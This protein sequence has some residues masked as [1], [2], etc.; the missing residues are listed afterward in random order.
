MSYS[1]EYREQILKSVNKASFLLSELHRSGPSFGDTIQSIISASRLEDH[2]EVSR[3]AELVYSIVEALDSGGLD[4]NNEDVKS[5][6]GSGLGEIIEIIKNNR[7]AADPKIE[8]RMKL[9]LRSAK[10]DERDYVFSKMLKVLYVDEDKF[11]QSNIQKNMDKSIQ[12]ESCFSGE[13]ALQRLKIDKFDAILCD[14]KLTN[15]EILKIFTEYSA[16]IPLVAISTS[17]DPRLVLLATKT[18][19]L[20]FITKN[21]TG[22]RRLPKSLHT[23]TT[24]WIKKSKLSDISQLLENH[25]SQKILKYLVESGSPIKQKIDCEVT[26]DWKS[27]DTIKDMNAVLESLAKAGY[28]LK[29]STELILSCPKCNSRNIR[30]HYL[31]QNCNN[32]NFTKGDVLEHNKCGYSGLEDKFKDGDTLVCPKCRKQLKLIG[33]DYFR[34]EAAYTCAKCSHFFTTPDQRY[35]CNIC[36]HDNF[37]ISD[38]KWTELFTYRINPDKITKIKQTIVSLSSI[39][40]FLEEKGFLIQ[41]E[42]SPSLKYT[43]A[44]KFDLVAQKQDQTILLIILGSDIEENFAKI[45]DLDTVSKT[46]PGRISKYAVIFSEPREVTKS[47][48]KRFGIVPILVENVNNMLEKFKENY[49]ENIYS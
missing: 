31:C 28:I 35:N 14:L 33:V 20:D 11:A 49:T 4:P 6:I 47:L 23:V 44:T 3:F 13:E 29:Q 21:D 12:I 37:R 10:S 5:V 26:Y 9:I 15:P 16:K 34:V 41:S 43:T 19:A 30:L 8:E 7:H 48:L 25:N 38:G 18:G 40:N 24:D 36:G 22:V 46:L 17:D 32:S 1:D 39:K 45:V 2:D 42:V 27:N